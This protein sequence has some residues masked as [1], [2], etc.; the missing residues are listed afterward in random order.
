MRISHT[1]VTE[2]LGPGTR[3]VIWV[4]GC[5]KR[6]RG[7]IN[8]EGWRIDGGI[9]RSVEDLV[10]EAGS[11]EE[12][13]GVTISGGEPFLQFD[14]LL[15]LV[16]MLKEQT[17]L[18]VMLYSGYTLEELGVKFGSELDKLFP[19]VD[20]FIDGEYVDELNNGSAY[21]GS[22]NQ[23]IYY[24]TEKYISERKQIDSLRSRD[25][26][27]EIKDGEDIFFIGIP[28]KGFYTEFMEKVGDIQ[29]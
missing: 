8:P 15:K 20:I 26:S 10:L 17:S 11:K 3:Y 9:E 28:P 7:C 16:S 27:F 21:K 1:T 29:L 25:F 2:S 4:Q 22:D 13:T 18:D 12:I 23:K 14:E 24:F 5:G 6:C 19:Y